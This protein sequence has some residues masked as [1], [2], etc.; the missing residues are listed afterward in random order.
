MS[1]QIIT[2][3][4]EAGTVSVLNEFAPLFNAIELQFRFVEFG[5]NDEMQAVCNCV[6]AAYD[7]FRENPELLKIE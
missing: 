4:K 3:D 5:I 2:I 1:K 7:F 6:E